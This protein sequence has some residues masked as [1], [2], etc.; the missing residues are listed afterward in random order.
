MNMKRT[1]RR[2]KKNNRRRKDRKFEKDTL[3]ERTKEK[4]GMK[5]RRKIKRRKMRSG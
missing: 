5:N 3:N 1:R 4:V 2:T